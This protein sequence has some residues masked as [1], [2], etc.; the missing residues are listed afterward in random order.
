MTPAGHPATASVLLVDEHGRWLIVQ[1]RR[2]GRWWHLPGGLVEA[3]ESPAAAARRE[4]AE[5]LGLDVTPGRLL[6]VAWVAPSRP[7]RSARLAF[8]FTAPAP[9][10]LRVRLDRAELRAWRWAGQDDARRLLHPLVAARLAGAM[11]VE[12]A[13]G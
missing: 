4:V 2:G 5:E 7:G 10:R 1:P 6:T 8:V 13:G 11:Y 9:R 3:G 12:Q